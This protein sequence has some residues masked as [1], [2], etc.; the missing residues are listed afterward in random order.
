MADYWSKYLAQRV[1]RRRALQIGAA[2]GTAAAALALIGCGGGSGSSTSTTTEG[3]SASTEH[4]PDLADNQVVRRRITQEHIPFDPATIFRV[5]TEEIAFHV[6]SALTTYGPKDDTAVPDLAS[7][8]EITDGGAA[9][10]FK[11]NKGVKWH[12][13]FGEFTSEDVVYSYKRI[14]DPATSSSYVP[15]FTLID[16]IQAPDAYTVV[17]KLKSPDGN[18]LH[19]VANYH[20]GAI[21]NRKAIESLG[22]DYGYQPVGTGPFVF[23]HYTPGQETVL[24]RFADYFK[25]PATLSQ[26]IFRKI[27]DAETAAIALQNEEIDVLGSVS[28]EATYRRLEADPRI[29]VRQTEKVGHVSVGLFNA[30]AKPLDD[31]RV[32]KALSHA[33]DREA[34]VKAT[35]PING[36]VWK[37]IIPSWMTVSNPDVPWFAYDPT[38]AKQLLSAAGATNLSFKYLNTAASEENQFYADYWS[39]IGVKVE[40]DLV[41]EP[42]FNARR[43][44]NDYQLSYRG[45]P[46]INPDDMLFGYFHSAYF[47][48]KGYNTARFSNPDVDRLLETA[49]AELDAEKRKKAYFEAQAKAMSDAPYMPMNMNRRVDINLKWIDPAEANPLTNVL[50]YPTKVYKKA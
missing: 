11:L 22:K 41:D 5:N 38:T 46:S 26:I 27:A 30:N 48:P 2:G 37:N 45:L 10:T 1:S 17:I 40:F 36:R 50:F 47:A 33:V 29:S 15:N 16:S 18:F 39:K 32:R 28:N 3:G 35:A 19:Q 8:W 21:V 20:Q 14:L 44:A 24:T 25:G 9:Y 49:R 42:T 23:D 4:S 13:N 43:V 34:V 31:P 7:A 12:K 6:Y